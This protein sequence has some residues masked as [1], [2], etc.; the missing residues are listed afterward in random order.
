MKW[1]CMSVRMASFCS[2]GWP[3]QSWFCH[4][5]KVDEKDTR[6]VRVRCG[7]RFRLGVQ[8][9]CQESRPFWGFPIFSHPNVIWNSPNTKVS[10]FKAFGFLSNKQ[11]GQRCFV[12]GQH[13][14]VG[15][16]VNHVEF[17]SVWRRSCQSL[18]LSLP[19]VQPCGKL[20]RGRI[21]QIGE[22]LLVLLPDLGYSREV[23]Q[24][25]QKVAH[26]EAHRA[27]IAE[28]IEILTIFFQVDHFLQGSHH[29]HTHTK[30]KDNGGCR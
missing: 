18:S 4:P 15:C 13:P 2:S 11:P 7:C 1:I 6:I 9:N 28:N 29:T 10:S 21:R 27:F 17:L 5:A 20:S 25:L 24:I 23:N 3:A 16:Y 19:I 8:R 12:D 14:P 22:G 26:P 30:K